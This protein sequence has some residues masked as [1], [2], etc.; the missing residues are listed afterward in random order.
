MN[1]P[2]SFIDG[3]SDGCTNNNL[4]NPPFVPGISFLYS[5]KD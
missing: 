1:E 4:D 5:H 2:S 3:S